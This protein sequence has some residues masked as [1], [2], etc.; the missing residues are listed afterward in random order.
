MLIMQWCLPFLR[1]QAGRSLSDLGLSAAMVG[2][3]HEQS[4]TNSIESAENRRI[5]G[6]AQ[7]SAVIHSSSTR[8]C[9]Q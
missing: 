1:Q 2:V 6:R 5:S 8:W 4:N 7:G 9:V 3:A